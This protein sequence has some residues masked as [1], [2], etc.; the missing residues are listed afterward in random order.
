MLYFRPKK[1]LRKV[2]TVIWKYLANKL[3]LSSYFFGGRH[4]SEEY[5][6]HK[7]FSR[8]NEQAGDDAVAA[9]DGGFRR[10][11][12]N[13]YVALPRDMRATAAVH[14]NGEPFDEAARTLMNAQDQE[15]EKMKRLVKDDYT[16][17]YIPPHFRYRVILFMVLLW[18]ITALLVGI[19]I[20]AP[21]HLGRSILKSFVDED[22]HDGYSL[23]VGFYVLWACY[24]VGKSI[25]RLDKR[26][27]RKLWVGPRAHLPIYAI[28]RALI[29]LVAISYMLF[30]FSI[31]IPTLL[32]VVIEL[33]IVIPIRFM[34]DSHFAPRIR[35]VDMWSLG[36]VY[37]NI[38]L[39]LYQ[40]QPRNRLA[41]GLQNVCNRQ[42]ASRIC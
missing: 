42:F 6:S 5:T 33:Y 31:L 15:A 30:F 24:L 34:V 41:G 10:V 38:A 25:D 40:L 16:V 36:I 37:S 4:P 26:R 8:S 17:V 12:N 28:K 35:I 9:R 29:W 19:F 14:E 20:G 1:V 13:D 39:Y 11:P 22:L 21:L 32:S 18:G 2:S 3:R 23:I 27:Q 7:W